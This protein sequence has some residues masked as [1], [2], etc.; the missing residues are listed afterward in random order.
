ME[1][2]WDDIP[3]PR[4]LSCTATHTR[5]YTLIRYILSQGLGPAIAAGI[6]L[7]TG[8]T[9]DLGTM[10]SVMLLGMAVALLPTLLLFFLDDDRY[11]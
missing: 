11:V 7:Y 3:V 9:W 10:Q 1:H 6:F 4:N 8:D 5:A 2:A